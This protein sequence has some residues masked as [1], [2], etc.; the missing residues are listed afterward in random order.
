MSNQPEILD[1]DKLKPKKRIVKLAGKEID[2]SVIP[3]EVTLELAE[4]IDD[5]DMS[6]PKSFDLVFDMVI[7]ICNVMNF[8]EKITKDWLIKNTSLEQLMA[9]LEFIMRPIRERAD[10]TQ[11]KNRQRPNKRK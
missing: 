7:K 6:S 11:G 8:D 5:I 1:L 3:S 4:K 9:M 10:N 2:V